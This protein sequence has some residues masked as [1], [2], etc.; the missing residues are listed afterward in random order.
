[1]TRE[2]FTEQVAKLVAGLQVPASIRGVKVLGAA[3]QPW[4]VLVEEVTGG[5]G[6][7]TPEKCAEVF[8]EI[9]AADSHRDDDRELVSRVK[10]FLG[11]IEDMPDD[12]RVFLLGALCG[13]LERR[14]GSEG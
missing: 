14:L 13:A 9:L 12:E 10:G 7:T 3:Q 5:F 2:E 4:Y 6:W 8:T 1:M 11:H